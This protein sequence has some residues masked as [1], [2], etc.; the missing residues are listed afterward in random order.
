[1]RVRV[2]SRKGG[3]VL[4]EWASPDGLKRVVVP[5]GSLRDDEVSEE[6]LALG[7][8]YGLPWEE[9]LSLE[10]TPEA[11]A[12][13]LRRRGIWTLADLRAKPNTAVAALQ[14]AYGVGLAALMQAA[15]RFEK[16]T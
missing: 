13:E 10:V 2:I 12:A 3:A 4:V 9:L 14:A 8:E 6:E 16:E 11:I 5:A 7:I 15:E 1:M